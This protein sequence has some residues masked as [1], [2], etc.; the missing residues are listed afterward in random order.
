MN[1][2]KTHNFKILWELTEIFKPFSPWYSYMSYLSPS[3]GLISTTYFWDMNIFKLSKMLQSTLL[4]ILQNT[5]LSQIKNVRLC[6]Q[7]IKL[8]VLLVH[9]MKASGGVEV[10]PLS[11]LTSALDW[12][13]RS[14]SWPTPA[15]LAPGKYLQYPLNRRL[16]EATELVWMLCRRPGPYMQYAVYV[17]WVHAQPHMCMHACVFRQLLK[18]II[19]QGCQL[20]RLGYIVW[21]TWLNE[22]GV[23]V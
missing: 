11:F 8:Q 10:Q 21:L 14:A 6:S 7:F 20:L 22:Y 1:G 18:C 5:K 2:I 13:E 16:S 17:W 15:M 23:L 3:F 19:Y 9:A 4:H 12:D